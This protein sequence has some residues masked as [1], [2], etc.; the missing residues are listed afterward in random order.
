MKR[1][2]ILLS[3]V[4]IIGC[5]TRNFKPNQ[6]EETMSYQLIKKGNAKIINVAPEFKIIEYGHLGNG[7]TNGTVAEING[8]YPQSGWGKNKISD[9]LV[10]VISGKGFLEMPDNKEILSEGDVAF[11]PKGQQIAWSGENLKVFIPCIPAW[12]NEQHELMK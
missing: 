3:L 1:I 5:K 4:F 8:R 7:I 2:L 11:I 10:Y 6:K 9:E 12:T